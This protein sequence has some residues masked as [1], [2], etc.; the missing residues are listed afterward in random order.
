[1][2]IAWVC[3]SASIRQCN[4][5]VSLVLVELRFSNPLLLYFIIIMFL[6]GQGSDL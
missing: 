6:A 4:I 5:V 3:F 2:E 1:M